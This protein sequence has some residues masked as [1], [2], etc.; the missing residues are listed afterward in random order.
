[1][2]TI[3][4]LL[5]SLIPAVESQRERDEAF[6]AESLDIRDLECRMRAIDERGRN[7]NGGI[8]VGLYTR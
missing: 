6:L 2:N 7:H 1:M 3:L 5:K 4:S 8:A